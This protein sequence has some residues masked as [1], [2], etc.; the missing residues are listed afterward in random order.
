MS[1][2]EWLCSIEGHEFFIAVEPKFFNLVVTSE[3]YEDITTEWR[4]KYSQYEEA[5]LM[6][7]GLAPSQEDEK[8]LYLTSKSVY[9]QALEI[10]GLIHCMYVCS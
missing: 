2:I 1:W 5:V 4:N 9:E 10:Y 8:Q 6:I 7:Q 3:D